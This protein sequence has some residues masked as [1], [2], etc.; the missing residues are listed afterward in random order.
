[1]KLIKIKVM[2]L[3]NRCNN[4]SSNNIKKNIDNKND[5]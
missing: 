3:I 1:M 5:N 4:S 2:V